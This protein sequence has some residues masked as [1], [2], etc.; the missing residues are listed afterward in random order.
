MLH[1]LKELFAQFWLAASDVYIE[2]GEDTHMLWST[3]VMKR[4]GAGFF[5]T[6]NSQ[7][8]VTDRQIIYLVNHQ[9]MADFTTHDIVTNHNSNFLS[10]LIIGVAFPMSYVCTM[11]YN[12]L[13]LFR[14]GGNVQKLLKWID[15]QWLDPRLRRRGLIVYPEG[16]RSGS[17]TGVGKMKLGMI[18]YAYQR[19][20]PVQ[21][22]LTKGQLDIFNENTKTVA[23]VSSRDASKRYEVSESSPRIFFHIGAFLDPK[24]FT[25]EEEFIDAVTKNFTEAF[26]NL[27]RQINAVKG[28]NL[29]EVAEFFDV[30]THTAEIPFSENMVPA[31]REFNPHGLQLYAKL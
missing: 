11:K 16:T 19:R 31:K 7:G 23:S 27:D 30:S 5:R 12:S 26:V 21:M 17:D 8:L 24:D 15:D 20:I 29:S 6:K 25:T 1:F 3:T 9:G 2:N 18:K 14:R 22:V 10:R 4:Y 28:K 13:W